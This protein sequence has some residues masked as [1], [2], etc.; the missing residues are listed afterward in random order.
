MEQK[1][2]NEIISDWKAHSLPSK[3]Y[4]SYGDRSTYLNQLFE[5]IK[6]YGFSRSEASSQSVANKILDRLIAKTA[7]SDIKKSLNSTIIEQIERS[8]SIV[9]GSFSTQPKEIFE[10]NFK[11]KEEAPL[12]LS[13]NEDINN[14]APILP[15]PPKERSVKY[16]S[17]ERRAELVKQFKFR[18]GHDEDLE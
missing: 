3:G 6:K 2:I 8:I 9:Y 4:P 18:I 11:I 13:K 12:T 1:T 15:P 14:K 7:K 16:L 5:E 10:T 17:E